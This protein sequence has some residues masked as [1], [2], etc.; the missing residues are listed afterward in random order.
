MV[1]SEENGP[2]AHPARGRN[3]ERQIPY[4]EAA[5]HSGRGDSLFTSASNLKFEALNLRLK[6]WE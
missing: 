3:I 5:P 2:G 6:K 4:R 1:L